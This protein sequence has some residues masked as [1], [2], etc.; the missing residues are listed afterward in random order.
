MI[1]KVPR[2]GRGFRGLFR[3]L[4]HGT[5]R[6]TAPTRVAWTVTRNLIID[7]VARASVLMRMT[8][9]KSIRVRRPVYHLV[10]SWA[11]DERPTPDLMRRVADTTCHDLGLDEHQRVYVAHSDTRHPHVHIVVN[12]VH[13]ETGVAWTASH[14]YRRIEQSLARQA[15]ELGLAIVPGRHNGRAGREGP[16]R[17]RDGAFQQARR[18][19][20]PAPAKRMSAD[21]IASLRPVLGPLFSGAANWTALQDALARHGLALAR[22]GQ[23]LVITDGASEVKLSSLGAGVRLAGLE[24]RMGP[25]G[26]RPARDRYATLRRQRDRER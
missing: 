18:E 12:R 17:S 7:D 15:H 3:Y 1:G 2:A 5:R 9:A 13:P 22:K 24:A 26:A 8:A 21:T 25:Y 11:H 4:L 14:D 16:R 10:I 23:G 19:G 20:R 6:S